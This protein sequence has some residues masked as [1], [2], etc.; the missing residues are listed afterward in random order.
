MA[1]NA[2]HQFDDLNGIKC[3]I[4]EKNCTTDR[5]EFIKNLLTH[6]GYEVVIVPSPPPKASKPETE[7]EP[8]PVV[9]T[10]FTVGVTDVSFNPINAVYNRELKT[11]EGQVV[12]KKFWLQQETT[13]HA[14][15]WYWAK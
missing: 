11:K 10:T 1:L 5:A 8:A 9:A 13:S 2:N 3:A 4:V 15:E 14:E 7:N 12:S 6:N